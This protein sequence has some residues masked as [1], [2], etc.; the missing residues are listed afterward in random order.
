MR[1]TIVQRDFNFH[2]I[3][4]LYGILKSLKISGGNFEIYNKSGR[5]RFSS[6]SLIIISTLCVFKED[7]YIEIECDNP[8]RLKDFAEKIENLS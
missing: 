3:M 2:K 1:K 8:F 4:K 7:I 6:C 5:Y